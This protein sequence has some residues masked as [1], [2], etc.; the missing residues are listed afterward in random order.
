MTFKSGTNHKAGTNFK[1][2]TNFKDG[3]NFKV[4]TIVKDVHTDFIA[5]TNL[6]AGATNFIEIVNRWFH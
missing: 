4:G 6:K 1:E 3:P 5:G 2:R